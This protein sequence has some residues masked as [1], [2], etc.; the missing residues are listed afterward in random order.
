MNKTLCLM[1]IVAFVV[2]LSGCNQN[3]ASDDRA[4]IEALINGP[5]AALFGGGDMTGGNEPGS[6]NAPNSPNA[7]ATQPAHW[8][9]TVSD[10]NRVITI[11]FPSDGVADVMVDDTV[12]GILYV[13]RSFDG[14]LNPGQRTWVS[15][16]V[17][18]ATFAKTGDNWFITG[19]SMGE[20]KLQDLGM[21]YVNITSLRIEGP[22]FD[23]TYNDPS[24]VIPLTELPQFNANASVDVT[25]ATT[26][27]SSS[28]YTP[29]TFCYLHHPIWIREPMDE[30][31][32]NTF[33]HSFMVVGTDWRLIAG[34]AVDSATFQTE[35]GSDYNWNAWVIPFKVMQ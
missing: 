30:S 9:R 18:Y 14:Q 10:W 5:Y 25:V 33:S 24:A 28:T 21:Q 26:N 29:K 1:A 2:L 3:K 11:D 22:G 19:I 13:D 31:P 16:H 15:R 35:N 4:E 8:W 20:W 34:D 17:K 6:S 12:N 27:S 7:T 32:T 23:H